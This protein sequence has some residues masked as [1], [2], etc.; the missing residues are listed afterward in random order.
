MRLLI[1]GGNGMAGHVLLRYFRG[2]SGYEVE[3]T[4]RDAEDRD[5]IPFDALRLSDIDRLLEW[6]KPDCVINAIGIL[7]A[8]AEENH[9]AAF[10]VNSLLPHRIARV[11][12]DLGYGGR[13]VQISTDCV[14]SGEA[15][16][17]ER[18]L[19][20][21]SP[22]GANRRSGSALPSRG[23]TGRYTEQSRPDGKTVYARTK[24]AG[25]VSAEPH[26]TIRTS[27]IGPEIR[28]NGIGLF[29]W[30]M[31]QRGTVPGYT[32]VL[33][34][35]IT[36]VQLAKSI[37]HMLQKNVQGLYH[38]TAPRI[39][40]KY[41]LLNMFAETFGKRDV[42]IE[43]TAEP[44]LDRTLACTRTDHREPVPD[45]RAMLA[46]LREWMRSA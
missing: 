4:S 7:N 29:E 46:E 11:L 14:F 33:W 12:D 23:F 21:P 38:L 9:R 1:L 34:N 8:K 10:I 25:E 37:D 45:Y 28:R 39:I 6:K 43:P 17:D 27:I 31:R 20:P 3:Y 15:D 32:N 42:R 18:D 35:G 30:F 36:T 22:N 5:A 24:A 44:R 2:R 40:S 26:L 41:E 13:L 19:L 16:D